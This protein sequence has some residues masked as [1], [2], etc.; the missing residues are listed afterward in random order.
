MCLFDN[1][2]WYPEVNEAE[3]KSKLAPE[4]VLSDVFI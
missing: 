1:T 2:E 4:R 3:L